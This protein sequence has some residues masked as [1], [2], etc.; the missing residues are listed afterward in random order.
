MI[1]L[2]K[3]STRSKGKNIPKVKNISK[4]KAQGKIQSNIKSKEIKEEEKLISD[5]VDLGISK[6]KPK[7]S[8]VELKHELVYPVTNILPPKA[9]P[10]RI[11]KKTGMALNNDKIRA[12]DKWVT[13]QTRIRKF[14]DKNGLIPFMYPA[15]SHDTIPLSRFT[16]LK[17][18][19]IIHEKELEAFV[20]NKRDRLKL[21]S[22]STS[23][24]KVQTQIFG[25]PKDKQGV[26]MGF[27]T[28][29]DAKVGVFPNRK[30]PLPTMARIKSDGI[31]Y[32]DNDDI[33][34]FI[35]YYIN[36]YS[37]PK[38]NP[39]ERNNVMFKGKKTLSSPLQLN[40][41]RAL[42]ISVL[43]TLGK[44]QNDAIKDILGEI[45]D[46]GLKYRREGV[47]T[48]LVPSEQLVRV[49]R[50]VYD[51]MI[52]TNIDVVTLD[53]TFVFDGDEDKGVTVEAF[54]EKEPKL[55]FQSDPNQDLR[56]L[57]SDL[58][59]RG[60]VKKIQIEPDSGQSLLES[61]H[62]QGWITYPR[63][64]A[65]IEE[66]ATS[67]KLKKPIDNDKQFNA[68][69]KKQGDF[70]AKAL[71]EGK[72]IGYFRGSTQEKQILL[73]IKNAEKAYKRGD[74]FIQIGK[75]VLDAGK[76][77]DGKK[78]WKQETEG[79]WIAGDPKKYS[80][81]EF[82][83]KLGERGISPEELTVYLIKNEIGTPATRTA[84]LSRLRNAGVINLKKD[85]YLVDSRGLYFAAATIVFDAKVIP[86]IID[87]IKQVRL[88]KSPKEIVELINDFILLPRKQFGKEIKV[89]GKKLIEA[90]AD[91]G[92]L[93]IH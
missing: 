63:V 55:Y 51:K 42:G 78:I 17:R 21:T 10:L 39:F 66:E 84:Q 19:D 36:A 72:D 76:T 15:N 77:L 26:F 80:D 8:H 85:K 62:E 83:I 69:K 25:Q 32:V 43:N 3:G 46:T 11:S 90:E 37:D 30:N 82:D 18:Y 9:E 58:L 70:T 86:T 81:K 47:I 44:K 28:Q 1:L 71:Q 41:N 93:E 33:G 52:T 79:I 6:T 91:F 14:Y 12:Y 4:S 67:I 53:G 87:Q 16:K 60:I 92:F 40:V 38:I 24:N 34:H 29:K 56:P 68:M 20:K 45:L 23:G 27:L 89:T 64:V 35:A 49:C 31:I 2:V 61:L 50:A 22:H 7:Q 13:E 59:L 5:I 73:M 88:A 65:G 57:D 48:D 74:L 54:K 75:W